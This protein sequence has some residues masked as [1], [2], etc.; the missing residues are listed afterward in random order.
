MGHTAVPSNSRE[1]RAVLFDFD[2]T[3]GRTLH[4]WRDAYDESLKERG[5][6]L[7]RCEL[8]DNCFHRSQR[9]VIAE[10]AITDPEI[11]KE[12][13]WSRVRA[14]V[15]HVEPYPDLLDVLGVFREQGFKIGIVSNSRREN[16]EPILA[17][18]GI[19]DHFDVI[20]TIDDVSN[21][22]PDPE[23]IHHAINRL[24]VSPSSTFYVGDWDTDVHAA[25]R[26][27]AKT[28][29]FSPD[30]NREF[31]PL[32]VLQRAAPH[33]VVDSHKSLGQL[34]VPHRRAIIN[35][36]RIASRGGY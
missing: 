36:E 3:M 25:S 1:S 26:A 33:H 23:A 15:E 14:L 9:E 32:E 8:I 7:D 28:V 29:A 17:R 30:E 5:I 34:L 10:L 22:K 6:Q 35:S 11:F 27:G 12:S 16:I 4:M 20:I 13:V 31:L 24:N 18:W 21:G 2:G 19:A